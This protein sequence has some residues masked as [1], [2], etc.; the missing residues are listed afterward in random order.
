MKTSYL[1]S[2][3]AK[4]LFIAAI[5]V[6]QISGAQDVSKKQITVTGSAEM[7]IDPDQVEIS[8]V[9]HTTHS[10]FEKREDEFVKLCKKYKIPEDQLAFKGSAGN[11]SFWHD[12]YYWWYY[13]SSSYQSQTYKIKL[14]SNVNLM[15]FV[16]ELNKGW[17]QNISISS[18]SNKN[19]PLYRK[20]VKKE[21]IRM[22]K[23]KASYLLEA[24]DEKIGGVISIEE[25]TGDN[26]SKNNNSNRSLGYDGY[27]WYNPY[28]GGYY[29]GNNG[30]SFNSNSNSNMSS[31]SVMSSGNVNNGGSTNAAD[32]V[33][34]GLSKIKLRY[35]VKAVFEIK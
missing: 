31:N 21:A 8:V 30:N 6:S 25:V 2:T 12:W 19:M 4:G 7:S 28:Y 27:G 29:G 34:E 24:I 3:F 17:I 13:R 16:K 18:T 11:W 32:D 14:N 9:L 35:E 15:E 22:A 33:M 26:N 5:S 1:K 20:E 10:D 23:E